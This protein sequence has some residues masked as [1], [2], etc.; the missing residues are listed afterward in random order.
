[1][2]AAHSFS[3]YQKQSNP[4]AL[5]LMLFIFLDE[6]GVFH[7]PMEPCARKRINPMELIYIC[8]D[9]VTAEPLKQWRRLRVFIFFSVKKG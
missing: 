6:K 4:I 8:F 5:F 7:L 3:G 1:L 2:L 9:K